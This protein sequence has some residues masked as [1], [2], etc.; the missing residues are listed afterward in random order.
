[1]EIRLQRSTLR[2]WRESDAEALARHANEREIS[3]NMRDAFPHPYTLELARSWLASVAPAR[4]VL[5]F[6]IDVAG[7]A[8]GGIG[9]TP[10][11]D[12]YRRSGEIGY[13]LARPHWNRGIVSEAVNAITNYAFAD[14]DLVR[15][16]T[17]VFEWN[18]A[19]MRVL[20]KCGYAREGVQRRAVI[21]EGR[22]ADCML[23]ARL[24]PDSSESA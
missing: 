15:V 2:P 6:A 1:M 11:K 5:F 21:K 10:L 9:V 23:Y 4:P 24:R 20:E 14:L 12:V 22:L 13:W 19:S 17:G 7:E 16:Q 8:V 3:R 18:A